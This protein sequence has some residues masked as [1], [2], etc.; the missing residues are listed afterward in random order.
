MNVSLHKFRIAALA[1][2]AGWAPVSSAPAESIF[3]RGDANRNGALEIAD[4]IQTFSFLFLGGLAPPCEDAADSNDSGGIDISDGIYVLVYLF[5]GGPPPPSPYPL[6]GADPTEDPLGC[7]EEGACEEWVNSIG[8][9]FVRIEPGSFL[10]GSPEDERGRW[11]NESPVHRVHITKAFYLGATEV[12]QAHYERVMGGNPSFFN[13]GAYGVDLDRPVEQVNFDDAVEFCRRLS[14][15][16]GRT[17]RLPTEAEWEYACRA[18]TSARFFFGDAL[19][20]DDECGPCASAEPFVWW[21]GNAEPKT[22]RPVAT[23]LPNPW[24]LY[25][26]NGNVKEWCADWTSRYSSAEVFDPAGPEA[27]EEKVLRGGC[28]SAPLRQARSAMRGDL[29]TEHRF[30]F[31]GFRAALEESPGLREP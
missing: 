16:E 1:L 18:G 29:S 25:D 13:G 26:M 11:F 30:E 21:C 28:F 22:T 19:D 24:C 3:I 20:C 8:M 15:L 4:S 10:M 12:T 2:A 23:K 6:A 31:L 17:Y 5:S 27:G 14:E 9:R 7:S